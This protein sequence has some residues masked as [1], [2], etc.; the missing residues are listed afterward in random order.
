LPDFAPYGIR[1]G[2]SRQ[3][4]TQKNDNGHPN[5]ASKNRCGV[6]AP[7]INRPP[8]LRIDLE[9]K[10]VLMEITGCPAVIDRRM[11]DEASLQGC[12]A[13]AASQRR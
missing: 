4:Q 7:K 3:K 1:T 8:D 2:P 11:R 10:T 6:G 9:S 5:F 13:T 12:C